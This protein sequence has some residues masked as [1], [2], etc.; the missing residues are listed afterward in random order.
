MTIKM[1]RFNSEVQ[2]LTDFLTNNEWPFFANPIVNPTEI[3]EKVAN[4]YYEKGRETFWILVDHEKVGLVI[5]DDI[6]DSIPLFDIRLTPKARGK[7]TG[8][9][10]LRW[11]QN[12]LFGEKGKIR[13]EAYTRTDNVPM[14]KCFTKSGFVKEGYLRKAW[15]NEDG[16]VVDSVLYAAIY[17]DWKT[18]IITPVQLDDVPY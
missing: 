18:G 9:Q 12:Y 6:D 16:T 13:I 3:K 15:E 14:R 5:I 17:D 11:L 1:Q 4:G 7:G 8:V 2:D 10:T